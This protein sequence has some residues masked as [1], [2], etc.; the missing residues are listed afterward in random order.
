LT[1]GN[2]RTKGIMSWTTTASAVAGIII[3]DSRLAKE[4]AE[5]LRA[6]GNDLLWNHS[7]RVYLFGA[8]LAERAG[9]KYD[10][11][12]SYIAALFH[13][14]GLIHKY[15]TQTERF[16]VDGANAAR[17]FLEQHGIAQDAIEVVWD[18]IALHTTLGI[19]K[20]KK[21]EVD[22][23]FNG[24]GLDVMGDLYETLSEA[25]RNEIVGA[26]PRDGFKS[27]IVHAFFEGFRHKP[28][29]TF[30]NIK[31]D[32]V[33]RLQPGYTSPNFVDLIAASSWAE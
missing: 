2:E 12:L 23:I 29:T 28:Q 25:T 17:Q 31:A 18:A 3:P 19:T 4:A 8:L 20:F 6:D 30:G 33:E 26:F 10:P 32:V 14:V 15:S 24:V 22:L 5:I 9:K 16:E 1:L 7:H 21:A 27:K 13:D 11:E